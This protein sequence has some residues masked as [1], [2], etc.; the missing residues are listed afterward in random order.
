MVFGGNN[1]KIIRNYASEPALRVG[2]ERRNAR[3]YSRIVFGGNNE[4]II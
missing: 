2:Q 4:E 3:V 1:G